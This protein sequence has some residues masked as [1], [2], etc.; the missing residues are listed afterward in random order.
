MNL[1]KRKHQ[2]EP[3]DL[4]SDFQE[5][6]DHYFSSPLAKR[7]GSKNFQPDIEVKEEA[8]KY[9][10]RVD[11]PGVKK[12]DFGVTIDGQYLTLKGTRNQETNSDEKGYHYTERFYGSFSRT[13]QLPLEIEADKVNAKYKEGVLE[14]TVP[15]SEKS[16][17]K[18]I[19]VSIN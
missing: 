4:L 3:L 6:L 17:P 13:I 12:E 2:W 1:I 9:V 19:D 10:V 18:K 11:L 15:K 5:D 16:K 8:D 14:V 7:G